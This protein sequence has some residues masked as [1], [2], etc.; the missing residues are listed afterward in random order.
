LTADRR[1]A[2]LVAQLREKARAMVSQLSPRPSGRGPIVTHDHDDPCKRAPGSATKSLADTGQVYVTFEA[3][4]TYAAYERLE[5]E[6]ARRELTEILLNAHPSGQPEPGRPERWRA[7][8]RSI[9]LDV[10]ASVVRE[11]RLAVVVHVNIRER[12]SSGGDRNSRRR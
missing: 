11:G 2:R 10:Q 3:A 12:N 9:D 8:Q 6:E 7:R 1:L 5:I 4:R